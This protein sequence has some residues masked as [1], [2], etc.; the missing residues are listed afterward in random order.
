MPVGTEENEV[1]QLGYSVSS[2]ESSICRMQARNSTA[3]I[4]TC[5]F[6]VCGLEIAGKDRS[7]SFE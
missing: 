5:S 6:H 1:L 2:F 3:F 7:P 4:S